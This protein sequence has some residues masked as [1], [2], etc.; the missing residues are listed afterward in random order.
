VK[1][2]LPLL[3]LF[4]ACAGERYDGLAPVRHAGELDARFPELRWEA[5]AVQGVR[6]PLYELRIF[7]AGTGR[8]VYERTGLPGCAHRVEAPLSGTPGLRWT[9]RATFEREGRRR[10]TPWTAPEG[11][12]RDGD[13]SPSRVSGGI[14]FRLP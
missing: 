4:G 9:V 3:A 14:P 1:G 6:T 11:E 13:A 7:E 8:V 5:L 12:G 2:L 10:R